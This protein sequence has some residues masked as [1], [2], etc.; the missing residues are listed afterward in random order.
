[1]G[2]GEASRLVAR[3]EDLLPGAGEA[4]AWRP[5]GLGG[6]RVEELDLLGG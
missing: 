3:L 2:V 1:M 4:E 5:R 6:A